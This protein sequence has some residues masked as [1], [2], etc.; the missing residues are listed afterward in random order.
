MYYEINALCKHLFLQML[1]KVLH[2]SRIQAFNEW[3]KLAGDEGKFE[4]N[5][6]MDNY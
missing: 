6:T 4:L 5:S 2:P 3:L 1:K